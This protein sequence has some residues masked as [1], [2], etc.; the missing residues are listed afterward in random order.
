MKTQDTLMTNCPATGSAHPYPSH[1]AQWRKYNGATA[2]LF[3][4]WTGRR[5]N[6]M[7]VGSD[8]FGVAIHVETEPY[9]AG[10][11]GQGAV[12]GQVNQDWS[13]RGAGSVDRQQSNRLHSAPH[14]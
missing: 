5:R 9:F 6:A 3:N 8:P 11:M 12:V 7:D 1:A 4:P 10:A 14:A 13:I 2:W